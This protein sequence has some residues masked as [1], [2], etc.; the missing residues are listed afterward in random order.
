MNIPLWNG[1]AQ[2]DDCQPRR[3]PM[4]PFRQKHGLKLRLAVAV[5]LLAVVL[6]PSAGV[7]QE[8][9]PATALLLQINKHCAKGEDATILQIGKAIHQID[10]YGDKYRDTA[11]VYATMAHC[12]AKLGNEAERNGDT[13]TALVYFR[14]A[15]SYNRSFADALMLFQKVSNRQAADTAQGFYNVGWT[16]TPA[17]APQATPVLG[18]TLPATTAVPAPGQEPPG[19]VLG[20]TPPNLTPKPAPVP[21]VP[22]PGAPVVVAPPA[23]NP[24]PARPDPIQEQREKLKR[25]INNLAQVVQRG[26]QDLN[27][28]KN[29]VL[30]AEILLV[31]YKGI[32][33]ATSKNPNAT[34][35]QKI[36]AA[37]AVAT[38]QRAL[39][40]VVA[41]R[42]RVDSELTTNRGQ[43]SQLRAQLAKLGN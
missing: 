2:V 5:V 6:C 15:T 13:K 40:G 21:V 23:P 30:A 4:N 41:D 34:A 8:N 24:I 20:D 7:A 14:Q 9:N 1:L 39:D 19:V 18:P 26:E 33:D 32:Q 12:A 17:P 37:I 38:A 29:K 43:L 10:K 42:N 35:A 25:D 27:V 31:T 36:I 3:I 28:L 16:A 11:A 22:G